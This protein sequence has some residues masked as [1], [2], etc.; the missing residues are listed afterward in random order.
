MGSKPIRGNMQ[1]RAIADIVSGRTNPSRLFFG[2][3]LL[4]L[5]ILSRWAWIDC[6]GGTPSLTEYGYFVTDEGYYASGGKLKFLYDMFINVPLA[7]PCTYA[8][9]PSSHLLTWVSFLV[10]GQTTWAHRVFP[11]LF[12]TMAWMGLFF[13]LSRKTRAWIAFILCACCVLN[14]FLMVYERTM[15]NDTLMASVLL[16][17]YI[18]ARRKGL[19]APILGGCI[20][21]LGLWIKPSIWVLFPIGLS[22][23][24]MS[25]SPKDR[26]RRI[27]YFSLGF[28]VSICVQYGLIRALIYEDAVSQ[29]VTIAQLLKISNSS[30]S[31]PNLFDLVSTFKGLSSFPRY[32]SDGLLGLWIPL[33]LVLPALLLIRR[34]T[35]KPIRL[36]GRLLLYMTLILYTIGISIIP[37]FYAHY[38]IPVI[39]FAPIVWF[40][41]RRDL[42]LWAENQHWSAPLLMALAIFYIV[43]S[44]ATFV[45]KPENAEE[46]NAF[47]SDAYKLPPQIIW[48]RS[49]A[50]ILTGAFILT[51]LGMRACSAR[52]G[53]LASIGVLLSALGVAGLC[54]SQ[55]PICEAYKYTVDQYYSVDMKIIAHL[56][57]VVS[58]LFFFIV[59]GLPGRFRHSTRWY[60]LFILLFAGGTLVNPV[61]RKGACELTKRGHL[62]KQAVAELAARL[63]D[64]AVVFGE[65]APQLCLSLKAKTAPIPNDDPVPTLLKINKEDPNRPLCMLLDLEHGRQGLF[66]L[67][68]QDKLQMP[69]LHKLTLPSFS[70]GKPADVYLIGLV[71]TN[72]PTR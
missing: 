5:L 14:P 3:L 54:Y 57:Q 7:S 69:L 58:V 30:Y 21:G 22:A 63:P 70:T 49:G 27:V 36:D 37:T 9:C 47:L 48:H 62:H 20:F 39:T 40:E 50:Y 52:I 65:R 25:I 2:C 51:A 17:G 29:D 61:W 32:P 33:F 10:F 1:T 19:L 23:A 11:F 28:A 41:A 6:D 66:F 43:S 46:I 67:Q 44:F 26:I 71:I 64:N 59:W 34:L 31:L 72:N 16:L 53:S 15:C 18:V 38:Y 8:I 13:F 45:V 55:I 24:A 4:L 12:C 56:L 68:H 35:E 60:F 42:K